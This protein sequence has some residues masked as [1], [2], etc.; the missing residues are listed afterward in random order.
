MK[1]LSNVYFRHVRLYEYLMTMYQQQSNNQ[2]R[3]HYNASHDV[4]ITRKE[5]GGRTWAFLLVGLEGDQVNPRLG[6]Q[7]ALNPGFI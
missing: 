3:L 6:R 5:E 4:R 7:V 1:A 2:E